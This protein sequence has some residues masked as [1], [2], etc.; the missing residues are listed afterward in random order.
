MPCDP[1]AR[2]AGI[3]YDAQT[4][5]NL[6][7]LVGLARQPYFRETD[8]ELVLSPGY[9]DVAKRFGVFE[10]R[11][12]ALPDPTPDAA[13][14]ALGHLEDLLTGFHFVSATDRAAALSAMFTAV[15]R[16]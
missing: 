3:L 12:F 5:C 9:D 4:F 1:P 10:A 14:E 8:G 15:V 2:H 6:S 13:R 11:Q 7:P 16:P